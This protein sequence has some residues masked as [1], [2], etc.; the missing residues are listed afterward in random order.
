MKNT[1]KTDVFILSEKAAE[2]LDERMFAIYSVVDTVAI[3]YP[4]P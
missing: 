3:F 2:R 4:L 1:L